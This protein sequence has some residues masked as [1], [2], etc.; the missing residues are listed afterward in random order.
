M[1]TLLHIDSSAR[2]GESGKQPHGSHTRRLTSHF[3]EHWRALLPRTNVLSRD[4]AA[5]PPSPVTGKWVQ[6]AFTKPEART[7]WM[8]SV[9]LESDLLVDELLAADVIVIGAPMYNFGVPSS[10]KAWIDNIVRVGRTFGFDRSRE[11]APYWPMVDA[12]KQVV[13][14]SARGDGGYGPGGPL[15]ASN[16]VEASIRVPLAYVGVSD[17]HSVAAEWDEFADERV[18]ASLLAAEAEIEA[19][20][21]RLATQSALAA[22]A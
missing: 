16:L 17:F 21:D 14:L 11:G 12:G 3:L 13:V 15:A 6:A 19:L 8:R 9:L 22:A 10:L 2:S 4:V 18:M 1:T 5:E 7:E 20:V